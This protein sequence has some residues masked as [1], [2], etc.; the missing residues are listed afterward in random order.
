MQT[1]FVTY[2][3]VSALMMVVSIPLIRRMIKPN[4]I[5]GFRLPQ[6]LADTDT[7]YAV[8]AFGGRLLFGLGIATALATLIFYPLGLSVDAYA[9]ACVAVFLIGLFI[10]LGLTWRYMQQYLQNKKQS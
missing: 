4:Y 1:I 7:W 10:S 9:S 2:L 5:Y 8:N 6:T 3:I